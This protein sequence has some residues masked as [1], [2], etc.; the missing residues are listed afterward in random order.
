[1]AYCEYCKTSYDD[2]QNGIDSTAW[3]HDCRGHQR[4]LRER[5]AA[6]NA[7]LRTRMAREAAEAAGGEA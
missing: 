2:G 4:E 7:A 1:M 6:E 5:L 3:G